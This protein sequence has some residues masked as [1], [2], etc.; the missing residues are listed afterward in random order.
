MQ[1]SHCRTKERTRRARKSSLPPLLPFPLGHSTRRRSRRTDLGGEEVLP[2]LREL[3]QVLVLLP[4]LLLPLLL[5]SLPR[6]LPPLSPPKLLNLS[7]RQESHFQEEV[8]RG[9]VD[10]IAATQRRHSEERSTSSHTRSCDQRRLRKDIQRMRGPHAPRRSCVL[11][12]C[13]A[14]R[15]APPPSAPPP[16]FSSVLERCGGGPSP[17]PC[18]P[19]YGRDGAMLGAGDP[20][21]VWLTTHPRVRPCLLETK[22]KNHNAKTGVA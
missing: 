4:L 9:V 20:G 15:A 19:S 14:S 13:C 7:R 1:A 6:Q 17:A 8:N 12:T 3:V 2:S 11:A 16:L 10:G 5:L 21:V 18:P 22:K